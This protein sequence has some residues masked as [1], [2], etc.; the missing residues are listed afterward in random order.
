MP[1]PRILYEKDDRVA[2]IT[3]NRPEVLNVLDGR[4]HEE[5]RDAWDDF[6]RDRNLWVGVLTGA[7]ER[8]FSAGQDLKERAR[9]VENGAPPTT[10]GAGNGPG[11][12]RL[13]ERFLMTK[14][15]IARVNGYALGG[16]FELALACDIIVAAEHA[17]FALT[18]ARLGLVPGAGGFF[19]LMRQIPLKSAMGYALTGRPMSAARA[20][21]L[22]LVNEVVP[23][24]ELDACVES[25]VRDILR[26]SPTAVRVLK[27]VAAKSA[28]LSLA[29]TFTT[30]YEWEKRRLRSNDHVEGVR[31]FLEKREPEWST[32][33]ES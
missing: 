17:T 8:T 19:R 31:A 9:M 14:P 33:E 27:E 30:E 26:C 11:A 25:W 4:T 20:F 21:Q 22:G 23:Y 28:H 10:F 1:E 6:E 12:P 29:D 3:I 15:L 2:R 5:L 18:E 16:G 13:T 24:E 7:G 32:P